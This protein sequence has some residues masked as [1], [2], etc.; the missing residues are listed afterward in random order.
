MSAK[1][2][3]VIQARMASERLPGKVLAPLVEDVPLLAALVR[4]INGVDVE[5]WLATTDRRDDD[6]TAMW[7]EKLGLEVFRG[8]EADVLSRFVGIARSSKADYVLRLTADNPFVNREVIN[9][10]LNRVD[11]LRGGIIRVGDFA[12]RYPLGFVPEIVQSSALLKLD[13]SLES[14][15]F[16]R[17]HVTLGLG[18][19]TKVQIE[20]D[21]WPVRGGWRWTIDEARDFE[22]SRQ[23]FACFGSNWKEAKYIEMLQMVEVHRLFEI[24]QSVLQRFDTE[25]PPPGIQ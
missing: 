23:A 11:L 21:G 24:N 9:E 10:L 25:P 22:M 5:L 20:V 3:G 17:E 8:D 7:G 1:V 4:R 15:D 14:E 13:E 16:R 6:V 12:R 18:D 19:D 2:V